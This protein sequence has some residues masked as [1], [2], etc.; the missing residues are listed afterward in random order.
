MPHRANSP[1]QR[2]G[3]SEREVERPGCVPTGAFVALAHPASRECELAGADHEACHVPTDPELV[4]AVVAEAT[5]F[6]PEE[7]ALAPEIVA[8][9]A[10]RIVGVKSRRI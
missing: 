10:D 7:H 6:R 9:A 2:R 3:R 1:A 5:H 4:G 8:K